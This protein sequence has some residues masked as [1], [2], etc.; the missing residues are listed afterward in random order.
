MARWQIGT[1]TRLAIKGEFPQN[2]SVERF[3]AIL[4]LTPREFNSLRLVFGPDSAV[5][6]SGRF[7]LGG[8]VESGNGVRDYG[9]GSRVVAVVAGCDNDPVGSL[10]GCHIQVLA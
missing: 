9:D 4:A 5:L 1:S 10:N 6:G 7:P 3:A 2:N 8:M